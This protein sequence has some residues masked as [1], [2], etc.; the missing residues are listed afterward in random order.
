MIS[1]DEKNVYRKKMSNSTKGEKN[2]RYCGID[3]NMLKTYIIDLMKKYNRQVTDSE[4]VNYAKENRLPQHLT[5]FRTNNLSQFVYF[6][7]IADECNVKSFDDKYIFRSYI[8]EQKYNHK[9]LKIEKCENEDVY[10]II[11]PDTNN[12]AIITSHIDNKFIESSGIFVH[13]CGEVVMP[14]GVCDLGSMNLVKFVKIV[15][16]KISFDFE[17]F[18]KAIKWGIRFLDMINDIANVPLEEYKE[19]MINK[20][21][22]G[23]GV[24][25]LGSLHFM[26]GIR[27]GSKESLELIQQISQLKCETELI[28]SAELGKEKGSFPLF[29]K[30]QYF[31][32]YWWKNLKIDN[33]IKLQIQKIGYMRNSH[34]SMIAPNGNTS[35]FAEGIT[36][37]C[38]PVFQ[39]EYVRWK[40]VP[41]VECR[42]LK[43]KGLEWPDVHKGEWFENK[44]FKFSTRG[45]EEILEGIN[46][47]ED[48]KYEIDKNRGLVKAINVED[49]G[50]LFAKDFYNKNQLDEMI[51]NGIFAT[52]N[53]LNVT[54]HIEPL[55]IMAHHTNQ[56]ISKTINVPNTYPYNDFKNIY[57]DVWKAGIK[58]ITTYREGTMAAV[59]E[60]TELKESISLSSAPKRPKELDA[61][62]HSVSVKGEK[63]IIVIGLYADAPYEMFGGKMNG[64]NFKFQSK[65][66]K[67]IKV[68]RGVYGLEIGE[69]ISVNHFS[70][71]FTPT[72][73]IMF[74]LASASL[75]HGVP[76]KFIVEQMQKAE[77]DMTSLGAAAARVLKK[78]IADGEYVTGIS[79]PD[80]HSIG[81][82]IYEQGC[83][84]CLNCGWSSCS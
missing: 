24:M 4:W 5:K 46:L 37:G 40:I 47:F 34:Q 49:Y 35:V 83:N 31:N 12:F 51:K 10:D 52:T 43:Q 7:N 30:E 22:I 72:E 26:L 19:Q 39:K 28:A 70:E 50:W 23:L 82:I 68:K 3:N 66:G 65:K 71:V 48:E 77:E 73:Q 21:R 84:K 42:K 36:G 58:G 62:I 53:E 45:D 16:D 1:D 80:C 60:K 29:D 25:G 81:S 33:D 15:S 59:L 20:R 6:K 14:T 74:R 78:Y 63:F 2:G 38:E 11:V 41:I 54:D 79:C 8:K 13:N 56:S 18:K 76:I 57:I 55:K 75:R 67:I 27:Y 32:S 69:D 61:D 64:L 9:V 17:S 44:Y